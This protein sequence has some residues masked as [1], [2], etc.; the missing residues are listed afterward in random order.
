MAS[1]YKKFN[2]MLQQI[3]KQLKTAI[4]FLAGVGAHHYVGRAL[5]YTK[6]VQEMVEQSAR[7]LQTANNESMV[8]TLYDKAI[9]VKKSTVQSGSKLD[10]DLV[11]ESLDGIENCCSTLFK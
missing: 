4:V 10:T 8:K 6:K 3:Q 7:D 5:D 2:K 9:A 1:I 11:R